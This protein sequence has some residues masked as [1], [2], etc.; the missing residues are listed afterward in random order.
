MANTNVVYGIIALIVFY[1]LFMNDNLTENMSTSPATLIQLSASSAYYPF[2][3]YGYGYR[4]PYYKYVAPYYVYD[5]YYDKSRFP[6]PY[7]YY[8][9]F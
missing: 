6:R 9:T 4:Y 1:F 7:G 5:G 2:W 8:R 3:Q